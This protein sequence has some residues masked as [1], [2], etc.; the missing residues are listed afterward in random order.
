M[1]AHETLCGNCGGVIEPDDGGAIWYHRD[2]M[3]MPC[4]PEGE[5]SRDRM[6]EPGVHTFRLTIA[7]V[8]A[9]ALR[10]AADALDEAYGSAG[11]PRESRTQWEHMAEDML[12]MLRARADQIDPTEERDDRG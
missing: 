11:T 12:A 5:Q 6:A 7:R 2:S 4:D 3:E 8:K 10:E 9:E 1:I